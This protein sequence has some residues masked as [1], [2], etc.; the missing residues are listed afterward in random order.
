M[1]SRKLLNKVVKQLEKKGLY[2]ERN[3]GATKEIF[4]ATYEFTPEGFDVYRQSEYDQYSD[5]ISDQ[6]KIVQEEHT[7]NPMS[8]RL[9]FQFDRKYY[10]DKKQDLLICPESFCVFFVDE[11]NYFI[12]I[13][14]RST[15]VK[16]LHEDI[17][18]IKQLSKKVFKEG[19]VRKIFVHCMNLHM[20]V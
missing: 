20:Y 13:N 12:V 19:V 15:D 4:S 14:L 17:S 7:K 1:Q 11:K 16:R 10:L 3:H 6:I 9:L 2:S 5:M 8:R 18:I